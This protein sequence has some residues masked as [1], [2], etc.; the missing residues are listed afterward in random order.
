[1]HASPVMLAAVDPAGPFAAACGI[2]W[3]LLCPTSAVA[4]LVSAA[5]CP[6]RR[7]ARQAIRLSRVG[8]WAGSLAFLVAIVATIATAS[9][10][11][12][13]PESIADAVLLVS[14]T[15]VAPVLACFTGRLSR[16]KIVKLETPE[17]ANKAPQ[18]TAALPGD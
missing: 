6:F 12:D 1:M 13:P 11:K 9:F 5:L 4:A 16:R 14:L 15:G 17:P 10:P 18:T 8:L 2:T 7:T 3:T